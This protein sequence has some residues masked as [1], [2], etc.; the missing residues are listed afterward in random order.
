MVTASLRKGIRR[1]DVGRMTAQRFLDWRAQPKDDD[2]EQ[3]LHQFDWRYDER[4][5]NVTVVT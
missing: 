1:Q 3:F 2:P 4:D 5:H